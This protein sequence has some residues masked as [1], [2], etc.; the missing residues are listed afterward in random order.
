MGL[1]LITI[2]EGATTKAHGPTIRKKA[3]GYWNQLKNT[4]KEGGRTIRK[5]GPDTVLTSSTTK[6]FWATF[7]R[8]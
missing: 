1:E 3:Q 6:S 8:I 5:A 4:T 2:L 7:S